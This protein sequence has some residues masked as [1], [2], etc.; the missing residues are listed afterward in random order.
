MAGEHP[1]KTGGK[2]RRLYERLRLLI[3]GG[4]FQRRT[5]L[6]F[7]LFSEHFPDFAFV[8][9]VKAFTAFF[10]GFAF[11]A[12]FPAFLYHPKI[13]RVDVFVINGYLRLFAAHY[14]AF[15]AQAVGARFYIVY[16]H[17]AVGGA[18]ALGMV[19]NRLFGRLKGFD[20]FAFVVE[21]L[22]YVKNRQRR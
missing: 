6:G 5:P 7:R 9:P 10:G 4:R 11:E 22:R 20:V 3:I 16:D 18:V 13:K 15:G 19:F 14:G 12:F 2:L 1:V 17:A 8:Y 21:L